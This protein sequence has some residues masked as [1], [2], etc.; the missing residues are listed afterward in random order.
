MTGIVTVSLLAQAPSSVTN[1]VNQIVERTIETVVPSNTG[2]T[3]QTVKETTV[4]VK[5]DDLVTESISKSLGMTAR[6]YQDIATS[7]QVVGLAIP[8]GPNTIVTDSS[9]VSGDH[10]IHVGNNLGVYT[11]SK[12]VPEIGIAVLVP[13]SASS[14]LAAT[15][16]VGDTTSLKLGQSAIGI[17]SVTQEKVAIGSVSA[18]YT[19]SDVGTGQTKLSVRAIETNL[20][21]TFVPGT[22]LI[23]I[24]GDVIGISTAVSQLSGKGVFVAMSDITN[25]LKSASSTPSN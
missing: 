12:T 22:P 21:N 5:E 23:N 17:T 13:K 11:V 24:F 14:T 6:V 1:T 19:L 20:S 4:V 9:I 18:R 10:L 7:S 8:L 25:L 3:V 2:N 15:F 16:R